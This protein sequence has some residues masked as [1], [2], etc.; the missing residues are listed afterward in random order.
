MPGISLGDFLQNSSPKNPGVRF[1]LQPVAF[2][3]VTEPMK[4]LH[5]FTLIELLVV[6]S[7]ISI[8]AGLL[9]P[10]FS[11]AIE[12]S[13]ATQCRKNLSSLGAGILMCV[14]DSDN[15][16]FSVTASGYIST[17]HGGWPV[18]LQ[19]NYVKDWNTYRSPF[20]KVTPTRPNTQ[21]APVPVSYGLNEKVFDTVKGHWR[22]SD[23]TVILAAAAIDPSGTGSNV[24]FQST[25]ISTQNV[26][27]SPANLPK[28]LGTHQNRQLINVLF[29]DGHVEEWNWNAQYIQNTTPVQ[30]SHWDP[31]YLNTQ[32]P[33]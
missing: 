14:Y 20:D 7:I 32:I 12:K 26:M 2:F 21:N 8:L 17:T 30:M 4:K 11:S 15:R 25:A 31:M 13:R 18:L 6:I 28:N 22:N 27:V 9:L 24:A 23:F 10:V 29:A 1:R 33:Q 19:A 5:A 16:M 3:T